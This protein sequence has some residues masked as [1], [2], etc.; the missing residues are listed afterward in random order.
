[1]HRVRASRSLAR[2]LRFAAVAALFVASF[3]AAANLP[4]TSAGSIS[5][6][7]IF[8]ATF[9]GV[10]DTP[11]T[12][13]SLPAETG[14]LTVSTS[15]G[16]STSDVAP[17]TG[18]CSERLLVS[19]VGTLA[20]NDI[21]VHCAPTGDASNGASISIVLR[22]EQDC[23]AFGGDVSDGSTTDM[24]CFDVSGGT[25]SVN[26]VALATKIHTGT[27]YRLDMNLFS[28]DDGAD[29][30][31]VWVTNLDTGDCE[32]ATD[33][34]DGG[35]RPV[36]AVGMVKHAGKPGAFSVDTISVVGLQH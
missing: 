26:G 16:R 24:L 3:L 35:Y 11:V 28:S 6:M 36:H 9:S 15:T 25:L 13:G 2:P 19:D 30:W 7:Q 17:K 14:H 10:A 32:Y 33:L 34:I 4:S 23:T 18:I 22:Q 29:Y 27:N 21:N 5:G 20:T 12:N 8:L 31:E 1:V